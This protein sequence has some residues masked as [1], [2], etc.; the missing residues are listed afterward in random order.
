MKYL[1]KKNRMFW[2]IVLELENENRLEETLYL[3]EASGSEEEREYFSL[4]GVY[5]S[6]EKSYNRALFIP[7]PLVEKSKSKAAKILRESLNNLPESHVVSR[8]WHDIN[9]RDNSLPTDYY[10]PS[11]KNE[12]E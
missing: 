4:V 3:L 8:V 1:I 7:L 5:F 11:I 2:N 10:P 6:D 9:V 12:L